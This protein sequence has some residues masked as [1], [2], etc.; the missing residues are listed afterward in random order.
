MTGS[1]RH[2]ALDILCRVED[3]AY[4]DRLLNAHRHTLSDT[5]NHLLL[6]LVRGA[7]TYQ[8]RL[9]HI[10][11]AY[12]KKPIHKQRP[13]LRNILRLGV[14]QLEHLDRIP[15]YAVVSESVTLSRKTIDASTAKM[16]NA[17]LRG[18][19]ENRKPITFPDL[20]TNPI[21]HLA[22]STS[23]PEWLV[24]R[25]I[26]RYGIEETKNI[27]NANNTTPTL[28]IR[29]NTLRTT[30]DAL[31]AQLADEGIKT[32]PSEIGMLTVPNV[33]HLFRTRAYHNGLFTVQGPGAARVV[34]FLDP[35]P[36]ESILDM[37]SA[38]GGKTTAIAEYTKDQSFI[39]A[40]DLYPGRLKILAQ[41]IQ[42]LGV[43]SIH[44]FASDA[45]QLPLTGPFDRV[46][47][48]APCAS[49]GILNHHPDLRWRRQEA[50]IHRL[51]SLQSTLLNEA[52]HYVRPN[53]ILVYSTCTLEPEENE[54]IVEGFLDNHPNF[55][56]NRAS[57]ESPYLQ[58]LPHQTGDD[59]VFAARLKRIS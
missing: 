50:D 17:I 28:T 53:G 3:G 20:Q 6:H 56:L 30:S 57:Q 4:A 54:H 55:S 51:A 26:K 59:G 21:K 27:C 8:A 45:Q 16:V 14:Y 58:L 49:L 24:A 46:L 36:G 19:S 12:L 42:R 5:D 10:L 25:W 1:V 2:I 13:R 43:T 40:T 35:Q 47:L 22:I 31:N 37:C 44:P 9:D 41:N 18:I 48:D 52:A 7:L 15:P 39:I 23:H 34:P 32:Q 33:N 29:P 11:S 38:P